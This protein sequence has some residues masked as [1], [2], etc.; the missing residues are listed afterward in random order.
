MF[1]FLMFFHKTKNRFISI[2]LLVAY[3]DGLAASLRASSFT[4]ARNIATIRH[5]MMVLIGCFSLLFALLVVHLLNEYVY[6][7]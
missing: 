1:Q 4:S 3:S 2:Y 6:I 5:L 7:V